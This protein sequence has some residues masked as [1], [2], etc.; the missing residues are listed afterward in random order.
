[1]KR[2]LNGVLIACAAG[3]MTSGACYA[4]GE[5]EW[6][7]VKSLVIPAPQPGRA[8]YATT[9]ETFLD[10]RSIEAA[11]AYKRAAF[12]QSAKDNTGYEMKFAK[13]Q[14]NWY[15]YDCESGQIAASNSG[16][17]D[18]IKFKPYA[19][20]KVGRSNLPHADANVVGLVCGTGS[21]VR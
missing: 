16:P 12:R 3:A 7:L 13:G 11:G 19:Q 18:S 8:D 10:M 14:L 2:L 9:T 6:V 5:P 17:P 21:K 20:Y 4:S 15:Y 1:M